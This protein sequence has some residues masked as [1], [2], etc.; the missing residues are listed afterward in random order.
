MGIKVNL[1][2]QKF[3]RLTVIGEAPKRRNSTSMLWRCKCECKNNVNASTKDLKSGHS[4]SCGCLAHELLIK[5]NISNATHGQTANR[6][7]SH[8]YYI[9]TGIKSRCYN[10]NHNYY[11]YY[12]GRGIKMHDDWFNS[13]ECFYK[14]IGKAPSIKHTID[15]INNNGNYEPSNIQWATRK[16]QANNRRNT[17]LFNYKGKM[18]SIS[19]IADIIGIKYT[20]LKARLNLNWTIEK[21]ASESVK[22]Y[23]Y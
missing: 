23:N 2:G 3:N 9:W 14:Y 5:R 17:R 1:I 21:A 12:G 15:R 4:K 6:N 22:I 19:Q 13:F 7:I 10:I 8:E 11:K 18:R 16:D 20:T